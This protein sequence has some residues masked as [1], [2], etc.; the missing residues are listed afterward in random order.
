MIEFRRIHLSLQSAQKAI[1]LL[2]VDNRPSKKQFHLR[3][4]VSRSEGAFGETQLGG[5]RLFCEK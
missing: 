2:R 1:L 4:Q 5:G 3:C